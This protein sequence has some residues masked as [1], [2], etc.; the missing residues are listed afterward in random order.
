LEVGQVKDLSP[1]L[2]C[3]YLYMQDKV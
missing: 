1:P 3:V 2:V